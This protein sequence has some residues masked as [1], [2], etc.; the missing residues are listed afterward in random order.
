MDNFFAL[1]MAG[2]GGTR[3]WPMSRRS[4][5]KQ[6]LPL[7]GENSMF[8]MAVER[9]SPLFPAQRILVVTGA[10]I[11]DE[12]R[13]QA[14]Q[15]PAENFV[16]EPQGRNTAPAIGLA[17]LHIAARAPQ[18]TIAVLTADHHIADTAGFREVLAAT[19]QAAAEGHIVTLG[20]KPD[21]PATGFG[22]IEQQALAGTYGEFEAFDVAAFTEKP[23]LPT[24]QNFAASGKH[25]WNSGMFVWK[26]ERLMAELEGQQPTLSKQLQTIS[27][28]LGSKEYQSTLDEV[29]LNVENI[30]VDYAIMEGAQDVRVMPVD[31]GWSDVGSWAALLEVKKTD[32]DGNIAN[33]TAP[34]P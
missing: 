8:A 17:A 2:G 20:I 34:Q 5:P 24:A 4:R 18:A 22:Y 6:M 15:L 12:L 9:L 26:I 28:S 27:A 10:S 19:Y 1:I 7:V 31:I 14:P 13:E 23:D 3:L 30:S 32:S 16:V 33:G 25:S 21:H 29:W 11:V